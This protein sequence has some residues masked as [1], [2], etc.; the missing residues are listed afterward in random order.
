MPLQEELLAPSRNKQP[1]EKTGGNVNLKVTY[2]ILLSP[3]YRVPVLHF[4]VRDSKGNPVVDQNTIF[5]EVVPP[6]FKSQVESV[7][8]IG[9]ISMTV[10]PKC[11]LNKLFDQLH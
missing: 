3:S 10:T 8:V 6:D 7:G 11:T 1:Y 2:D 5:T 4:S 9:G